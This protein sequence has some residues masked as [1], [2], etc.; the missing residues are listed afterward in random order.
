MQEVLK[1]NPSHSNLVGLE[2][3]FSTFLMLILNTVPHPVVTPTLKF[4]YFIAV[5]L[6][7]W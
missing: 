1:F 3:W 5:V 7:L 4:Y 2:H 6:L